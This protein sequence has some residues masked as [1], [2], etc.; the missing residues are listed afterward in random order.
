[1]NNLF[2]GGSIFV[3]MG[4]AAGATVQ[5]AEPKLNPQQYAQDLAKWRA[6]QEADLKADEGFLSVAGLS[7]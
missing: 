2:L 5:T 3:A 7:G 6:G 1:M 4:L